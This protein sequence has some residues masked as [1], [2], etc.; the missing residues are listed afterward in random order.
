MDNCFIEDG[1][2]QKIS[3]LN[4]FGEH[5]TLIAVQLKKEYTT[6]EM[7]QAHMI[8]SALREQKSGGHSQGI[9]A[10]LQSASDRFN[11]VE[12]NNAHVAKMSDELTGKLLEVLNGGV[13]V[14][15]SIESLPAYSYTMKAVAGLENEARRMLYPEINDIL[16]PRQVDFEAVEIFVADQNGSRRAIATIYAR[17]VED[18][19]MMTR[20]KMAVYQMNKSA[21]NSVGMPTVK[22]KSQPS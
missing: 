13:D 15:T 11:E 8:A 18:K 19:Q 17:T 20:V 12:R 5:K 16:S 4:A 14:E 21:V 22:A 9:D 3:K 2:T 10:G 6:P 7:R 1:S